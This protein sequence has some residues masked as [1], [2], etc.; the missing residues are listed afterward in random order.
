MG[1][2]TKVKASSLFCCRY[3]PSP[4]LG[5]SQEKFLHIHTLRNEFRFLPD[6]CW[7]QSLELGRMTGGLQISH[8]HLVR[9]GC[10][11]SFEILS[12]LAPCLWLAGGI[13]LLP[14]CAKW[15][16]WNAAT[17]HR[18]AAPAVW[19]FSNRTWQEFNFP[20]STRWHYCP[21]YNS[22]WVNISLAV[23]TEDV[24]ILFLLWM[25]EGREN[26]GQAILLI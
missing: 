15:H 20:L 13:Q 7:L 8:N 4:Y 2:H 25:K 3:R 14:P 12:V 17:N 24:V 10:R 1:N 5:I 22:K 16:L 19:Q 21:R 26:L 9:S 18:R 23:C 6:T 11:K